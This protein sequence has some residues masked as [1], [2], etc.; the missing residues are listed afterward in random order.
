[1]P[2]F[3]AMFIAAMTDKA[4]R[5]IPTSNSRY[6]EMS[7]SSLS[8]N[9]APRLTLDLGK[10]TDSPGMGLSLASSLPAWPC[11]RVI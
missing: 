4:H 10:A 6:L 3:V 7:M 1:M 8:R 11:S 9:S 5:I 2:V